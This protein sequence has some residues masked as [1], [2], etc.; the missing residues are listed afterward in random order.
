[1]STASFVLMAANLL[2]RYPGGPSALHSLGIRSNVRGSFIWGLLLGVTATVPAEQVRSWVDVFFPLT[3]E[4]HAAYA[5]LFQ[6]ESSLHAATMLFVVALMVPLA[7]E[8]FFRGA[9][10]GALRRSRVEETS[11]VAVTAV[12]FT[13]CHADLRQMPA[14]I[15]VALLLGVL[16][17]RS[18]SLVPAIGAHMGFN[19]AA[20]VGVTY[21]RLPELDALSITERLAVTVVHVLAL[22]W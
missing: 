2:G 20:I 12:G 15:L 11:A 1:V 8:V 7:E 16:R 18:G 19:G 10:Y 6:A 9:V 5:R 14:L 17:S 22:Y 4:E 13:L 21:E 3:A